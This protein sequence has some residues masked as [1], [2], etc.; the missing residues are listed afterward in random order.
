[1]AVFHLVHAE[2]AH[3]KYLTGDKELQ[4]IS[5]KNGC[6]NATAFFK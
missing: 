6:S 1:M 5:G 2:N 3:A 4:T